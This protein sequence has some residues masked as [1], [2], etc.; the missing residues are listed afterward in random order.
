[1]LFRSFVMLESRNG[2]VYA[3]FSDKTN[4]RFDISNCYF[5]INSEDKYYVEI[6]KLF[7]PHTFESN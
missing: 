4:K 1:V 2:Y 7:M 5:K 6:L 3:S